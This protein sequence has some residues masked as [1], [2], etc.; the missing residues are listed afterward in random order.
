MTLQGHIRRAN[1]DVVDQ[2]SIPHPRRD[3]QDRWRI[4]SLDGLQRIGIY[5]GDVVDVQ[6]VL[7][8]RP[9]HGGDQAVGL[10]DAGA[11][12]DVRGH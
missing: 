7:Q 6:V 8:Q 5:R 4:Y 9:L 12:F 2:P 10:G 1:G 11:E 3:G